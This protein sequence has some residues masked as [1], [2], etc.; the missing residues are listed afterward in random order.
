MDNLTTLTG[1]L[2]TDAFRALDKQLPP[3]AYK[4]IEGGKGGKLGLT[5]I[6]PA[7]LPELL[8]VLFGP[9]GL[10][11]GFSILEL[12]TSEKEVQR[13]GGYTDTE[14]T[15]TCKLGCWYAYKDGDQLKRSDPIEATGGSTNTLIE[16]AMKGA[17]TNALGCAWFLAGYQLSVYKDERGH[18]KL[19]PEP[20]PTTAELLTREFATL[21]IPHLQQEYFLY[22]GNK[23]DVT[24][25][26]DL[27]PANVKEQMII[28]QQCGKNKERKD[29]FIALL[30]KMKEAA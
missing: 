2:I 29:A 3:H 10:G 26:D 24:S 16:W 11:W 25:I 9:I 15:A 21:G 8:F 13:K 7:F 20:Q 22:V 14:Y 30:S 1:T 5:D 17:I 19:A 28:L 4:K 6:V 23:Y 18:N 27:T 12:T